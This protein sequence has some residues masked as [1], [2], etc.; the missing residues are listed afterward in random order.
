M[1]FCG[2]IFTKQQKFTQQRQRHNNEQQQN[3][4]ICLNFSF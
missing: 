3:N 1:Y 2:L 4:Q